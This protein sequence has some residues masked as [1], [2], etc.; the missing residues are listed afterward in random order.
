MVCTCLFLSES[1][2]INNLFVTSGQSSATKILTQGVRRKWGDHRGHKSS[3]RQT[4]SRV[5]FAQTIDTTTTTGHSHI[6]LSCGSQLAE[7]EKK[8]RKKSSGLI[9]VLSKRQ[10]DSPWWKRRLCLHL[11]SDK[12]AG[13]VSSV[14]CQTFTTVFIWPDLSGGC[15]MNVFSLVSDLLAN[16]LLPTV[17]YEGRKCPAS[18]LFFSFLSIFLKIPRVIAI[19]AGGYAVP[20]PAA[21]T[22]NITHSLWNLSPTAAEDS[23]HSS[24][25]TKYQTMCP[26]GKFKKE[27]VHW[28]ISCVPLSIYYTNMATEYHNKRIPQVMLSFQIEIYTD[29]VIRAIPEFDSIRRFDY[30]FRLSIRKSSGTSSSDDLDHNTVKSGQMSPA[31]VKYF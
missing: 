10:G 18:E 20:S 19:L 30:S 3:L 5:W 12:L 1:S 28:C 6:C 4:S 26:N 31:S 25:Q 8:R 15:G 7:E 13:I 23:F 11:F 2:T 14:K 21:M 24:A 16:L 9:T 17:L 29:N 27:N 22:E